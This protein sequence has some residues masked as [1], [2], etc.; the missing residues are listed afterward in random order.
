MNSHS[1]G[2]NSRQQLAGQRRPRTRDKGQEANGREALEALN[3]DRDLPT[4]ER[5]Q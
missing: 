4:P 3:A 1:L 2:Q 5:S